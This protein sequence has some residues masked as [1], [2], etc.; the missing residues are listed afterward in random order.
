MVLGRH[1]HRAYSRR[2]IGTVVVTLTEGT[3]FQADVCCGAS[4]TEGDAPGY[5]DSAFQAL[6]GGL[7]TS[8]F[9]DKT[10]ATSGRMQYAPR[11]FV[12]GNLSG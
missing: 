12:N 4:L 10:P 6:H 7:T 11:R 9:H 8:P 1:H 5:S 2:V 3:A